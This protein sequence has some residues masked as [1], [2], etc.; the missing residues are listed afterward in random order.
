MENSAGTGIFETFSLQVNRPELFRALKL[1]Q[2]NVKAKARQDAIF[3]YVDGTLS[4]KLDWVAAQAPATGEWSGLAAIEGH[5]LVMFG[6]AIPRSEIRTSAG[7][8]ISVRLHE[9]R[10]YIGNDSFS[11]RWY[12]EKG[13]KIHL[14]LNPELAEALVLPFKYTQEELA[15]SDL[16]YILRSHEERRDA[17][18][19]RA[20]ELLKPLG[21][22]RVDLERLVDDSIKRKNG[23]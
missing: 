12:D 10:L 23:L 1:L 20:H 4:I 19:A 14:P 3:S 13:D 11:L 18:I 9:R 17:I 21:V 6:K 16:L 8:T 15:Y 2:K 7:E 5:D 22:E